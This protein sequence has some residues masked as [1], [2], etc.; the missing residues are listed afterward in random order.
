MRDRL[1]FNMTDAEFEAYYGDSSDEEY[2][3]DC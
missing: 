1:D 3:S 2:D